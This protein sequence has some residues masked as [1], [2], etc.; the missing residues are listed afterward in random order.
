MSLVPTGLSVLIRRVM[1]GRPHRRRCACSGVS[2]MNAEHD[3]RPG[4]AKASDG[5]EAARERD[6]KAGNSVG[7]LAA[8][9]LVVLTALALVAYLVTAM[10]HAAPV[11]IAEVIAA[12][13]GLLGAAGGAIRAMRGG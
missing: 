6:A 8:G 7:V 10:P 3:A 12:A 5:A 1:P 13:A 11:E 9:I 2:A 4:E